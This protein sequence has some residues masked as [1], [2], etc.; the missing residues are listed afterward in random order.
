MYRVLVCAFVS[1]KLCLSCVKLSAIFVVIEVVF[2]T[3]TRLP[4]YFSEDDER[5]SLKSAVGTR[6]S[7]SLCE[8]TASTHTST[9]S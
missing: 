9:I 7:I 8:K 2:C 5:A 4:K 3:K 1:I 6:P